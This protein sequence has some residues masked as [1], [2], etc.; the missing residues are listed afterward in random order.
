MEIH[1]D[2]LMQAMTALGIG[3]LIGLEREYGQR[4]IDGKVKHIEA[5]GIRTFTMIALFGNLLTWFPM[6]LQFWMP[7]LGLLFIACI[8]VLSYWRT[9]HGKHADMG[10]TS[11]I[12]MLLTFLLGTLAGFGMPLLA[13]MVAVLMVVLLFFKQYLHQFSHGLSAMDIRQALLFLTISIIVLPILPDHNYGPYESLNPHRIWLMVVLIS[14]I[15]FAAYVTMKALGQ[16]SGLLITGILGGLASSTAVTLAMSRLSQ[17]DPSLQCPASLATVLACGTVFPRVLGLALIFSPALAWHLLPAMLSI[18]VIA[19]IVIAWIGHQ[20]NRN[21]QISNKLYS[22]SV[23]PLSLQVAL[24]FGLVFAIIV[25][26]SHF[27]LA[28]FG[29]HGLIVVAA[30]S[31]LS[32]VDAISLSLIEMS[33]DTTKIDIAAKGIMLA[34]GAN[35]LVKLA[36]GM[37]ISPKKTYP[38]LLYGLVPMVGL[39]LL[40][41]Y[42]L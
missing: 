42:L 26:L 11:E 4:E 36:I 41:A 22:P 31:G 29:Q 38:W 13:T 17:K 27:S 9:N 12:A 21:K 19:L 40:W 10:F 3:L 5:A 30:L 1:W 24:L 23:N 33:K 35:S 39:S 6:P 28:Q 34:C 25:F 16:R 8:S 14:G 2:L 18:I 20:F 32:D 7:A 15:G 37:T